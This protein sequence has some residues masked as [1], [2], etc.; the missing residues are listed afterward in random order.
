MTDYLTL[1]F[2]LFG[3]G[4]VLFL[5][6]YFLPT[7][8]ILIVG[9]LLLCAAGVGVIA[10]YGDP[11]ETVAALVVLCVGVPLGGTGMMYA[12]GRRMALRVDAAA[13]VDGD[14]TTGGPGFASD[15]DEFKGR[16]G[17]TLTPMRPSGAVDFDGRRVDAMTEGVMLD[18]NVWIKC[19]GVR[20][21]TVIVR[22]VP[23]PRD[24]N[25]FD[26]E[27]LK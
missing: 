3:L 12:W 13:G 7:G 1:A 19:V 25:E 22:Q 24:L 16:F 10:Y 15:L 8:G 18:A 11:T 5:A 2:I 9:G 6:E 14:A 26:V 20:A 4:V 27:D 17:R 21:G 23:K